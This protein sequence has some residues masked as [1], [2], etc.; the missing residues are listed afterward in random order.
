LIKLRERVREKLSKHF[1]ILQERQTLHW[2]EEKNTNPEFKISK[3]I[4]ANFCA[5]APKLILSERKISKIWNGQVS[6][7]CLMSNALRHG[8]IGLEEDE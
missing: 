8:Q 5:K 6:K 7:H 4:F 1:A 3:Q 2:D